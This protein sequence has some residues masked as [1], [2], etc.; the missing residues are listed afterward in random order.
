MII[1]WVRN[2][3]IFLIII[4]FLSLSGLIRLVIDY[5]WFNAL[6]FEQILIIS[7]FTKIKLFLIGAIIFFVFASFNVWFSTKIIGKTKFPF[8]FKLL[9]IGVL[10]III[11]ISS[12]KDQS[13]IGRL[14]L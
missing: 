8:K 10:S 14:L 4:I 7:L 2:I 6:G 13:R 11:G 5:L 3:L 1:D 12:I 9:I